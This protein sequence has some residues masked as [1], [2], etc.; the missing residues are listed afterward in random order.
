M[1]AVLCTSALQDALI[2]AR[3][4]RSGRLIEITAS[5]L[6]KLLD[7]AKNWNRLSAAAGIDADLNQMS[8]EKPC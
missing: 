8:D 1:F 2:R 4:E 7:A 5:G 6:A 3:V